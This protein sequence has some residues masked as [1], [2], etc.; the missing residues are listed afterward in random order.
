MPGGCVRAAA[1]R[2]GRGRLWLV[3]T[4]NIGAGLQPANPGALD[5]QEHIMSCPGYSDLREGKNLLSDADLVSYFQ[6]VLQR[7]SQ[8]EPYYCWP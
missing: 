4:E 7:R 1:V 5:T 6:Q 2:E 8:E 3:L